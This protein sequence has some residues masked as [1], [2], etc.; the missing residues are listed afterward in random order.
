[1]LFFKRSVITLD[2]FTTN[3]TLYNYYPIQTANNFF[4]DGWKQLPKYKDIKSN[5]Y[6][7]STLSV[8]RSTMKKCNGFINLFKSG[9]IIPM[10]T[11]VALEATED[12]KC[13]YETAAN[14]RISE[15]GRWQMWEDLYKGY[16]NVKFVS[17]WLIK[18]KT[19]VKFLFGGVE[20]HNTHNV[21]KFKISSGVVDYKYQHHSN[22]ISFVKNTT[23]VRLELG[24][25]I[26]HVI[27]LSEKRLEIKTHLI[28]QL[29]WDKLET[30][31]MGF[32]NN[33]NK[34]TRIEKSRSKCPFG[35]K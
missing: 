1:M 6:P 18:E 16:T 11:D 12:G 27:P 15:H 2:C 32:N 14:V 10:W 29:E 34:V 7:E 28:D 31:L 24:E 13:F 4:P 8:P 9:F 5:Q 30:P 33:Y 20:Y 21:D 26:V 23:T 35:F 22:I 17:P 19:G 3:P 25:P